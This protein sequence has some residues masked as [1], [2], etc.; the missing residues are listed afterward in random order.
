MIRR[1][2][3]W[4]LL[5]ASLR[6]AHINLLW[7]DED[8]HLAAAL[9]IVHGR[10]PY[11]DFWYDKP[12]LA[13]L[14]YS[15]IGGHGGWPLRLLDVAYVLACCWL[16]FRLAKEWWGEREAQAAAL[17]LAFFM[18]FYL[19]SATVPLA[20]DGLLVLPHLAAIYLAFLRRPLLCGLCCA[21]GLLVNVK[22]VFVAAA[23]ALWLAAGLPLFGAGLAA[24]LALPLAVGAGLRLLPDF[25]QQVWAWGLVY[26]GTQNSLAL[27]VRRCA[28]WLGFHAALLAGMIFARR[29]IH[30][31][32]AAW[33]A[34]S[35]AP[36]LLGNHFAPRYFFQVLPPLVILGSRGFVL[37]CQSRAGQLL[38]A[39]LLLIP[40]ARFGPRYAELMADNL[41]ARQ[42]RWPDAAMDVDAQAVAN[43]IN[44]R[45]HPGDTLFVWG[46][47]PDIYV[48][49]RL[50]PDGKFWDSQPLDGVPAD[51]HLES[52]V[53][54]P[55]I[56]AA[57][58]RAQLLKTS[59]RFVVDGLGLLNPALSLDQFPDLAAWLRQYR[60][61]WR[62]K[63]SRI[64][65]RD[66][67][68]CE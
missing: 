27:G 11:R 43:V 4:L 5:L 23:C 31:R 67:A 19:T 16:A 29:E 37:A 38:M 68:P 45:K 26:A 46:Y 63:L 64:Y 65:Q 25:Y 30:Y 14:F 21:A 6:L 20:V 33:L 9:Q 53:P 60:L 55:A 39:V 36:L 52:S 18:A 13:A 56:P 3:I 22:A 57:A 66:C 51:R 12:P 28:D 41:Q 50:L 62:T 54:H 35:A 59:P 2:P 58:N 24:G 8:Y 7:A 44:A 48:D 47:R 1:W 34:L 32:A 17:L 61:V 15:V 42:T 40:L 10:V 49:T